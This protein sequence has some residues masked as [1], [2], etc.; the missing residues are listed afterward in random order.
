MVSDEIERT[1]E[2]ESLEERETKGNKYNGKAHY[3]LLTKQILCK[4][5]V[6]SFVRFSPIYRQTSIYRCMYAKQYS[7]KMWIK[8][9]PHSRTFGLSYTGS[10]HCLFLALYCDVK[11]SPIFRASIVVAHDVDDDD[12]N[13]T[14]THLVVQLKTGEMTRK[15]NRIHSTNR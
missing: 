2:R 9:I 8:Y 15:R 6:K 4:R 14:R 1:R 13:N 11:A 7:L 5:T 12:N 3:R 10:I